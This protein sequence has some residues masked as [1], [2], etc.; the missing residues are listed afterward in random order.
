MTNL[1]WHYSSRNNNEYQEL[2]PSDSQALKDSEVAIAQASPQDA[3]ESIRRPDYTFSPPANAQPAPDPKGHTVISSH[4]NGAPALTDVN[5]GHD[6]GRSSPAGNSTTS[7]MMV[8]QQMTNDQIAQGYPNAF[9][10]SNLTYDGYSFGIQDSTDFW[11]ESQDVNMSSLS[12]DMIPWFDPVY[13]TQ[14]TMGISD[15]V[16]EN[17]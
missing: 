3:A 6:M 4:I 9:P 5:L 1:A 8:P 17:E 11:I 14:G 7:Q 13:F 2:L 10:T 12:Y 15:S 16:I